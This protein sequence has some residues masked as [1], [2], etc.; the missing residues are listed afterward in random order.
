MNYVLVSTADGS[1]DDVINA[2]RA[3]FPLSSV[4]TT[5]GFAGLASETGT[6]GF[7]PIVRVE[8]VISILVGISILSLVVYSATIERARDYAIMK[9]LGASHLRLYTIVLGQS[10]I[11]AALGFVIGIGL[12]FLMNTVARDF[13]PQFVTYIRW[14]DI[15]YV[16]AVAVVMTFLSS[17]MPL[18][19][20]AR[21]EPATVFRA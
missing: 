19:R 15:A 13:V 9:V 5:G 7:L 8:V 4:S 16:L 2:L 17:F 14:Q 20:I 12:T 11:I 3:E 10:S 18:H 21:I 1:T 6:S